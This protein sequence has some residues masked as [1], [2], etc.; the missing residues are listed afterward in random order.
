[1]GQNHWKSQDGVTIPLWGTPERKEYEGA[2]KDKLQS[3]F[4]GTRNTLRKLKVPLAQ[5]NEHSGNDPVNKDRLNLYTRMARGGDRLPPVI[6]RRNG[7]DTFDLIDGS[8]RRAAAH[9]AGLKGLDAYELVPTLPGQPAVKKSLKK[10]AIADI[11]PGQQEHDHYSYSHVLRP[12]HVMAGY[13]LNVHP[14]TFDDG[15][16]E[17]T[18][19]LLHHGNSVGALGGVLHN[20]TLKLDAASIDGPHR[21][22]GLG[23]A[24]YEAMYGHAAHGL[25]ATHAQ[26]DDHSTSAHAVHQKLAQ[27]HGLG[28]SAGPIQNGK[29]PGTDFDGKFGPYQYALKSE[30]IAKMAIAGIP[31]GQKTKRKAHQPGFTRWNY[32]HVLPE[33]HQQAGF[34][35]WLDTSKKGQIRAQLVHDADKPELREGNAEPGEIGM[36]TATHVPGAEYERPLVM[37]SAHVRQSHQGKGLGLAMYEALYAHGRNVLGATHVRGGEHS[38]MAMRVHQKLAQKHGLDYQPRENIG[39]RFGDEK[40]NRAYWEQQPTGPYDDKFKGYKYALKSEDEKD[41]QG[42]DTSF[43]FG[44]NAAPAPVEPSALHV[45]ALRSIKRMKGPKRDLAHAWFQYTQGHTTVRPPVTPELERHLARFGIVDPQGYGYDANG[46]DMSKPLAGKRTRGP[47]QRQPDELKRYKQNS[48]RSG[49][50]LPY[51]KAEEELE[52][53]LAKAFPDWKPPAIAPLTP[54]APK[55]E[56]PGL[57]VPPAA[58]KTPALHST[59]DGFMGQLK[60]LPKGSAERGKFITQHMNHGPFLAAL[61]AHPQGPAM[62]KQ[63]TSYLNGAAN[64]GF[65]AGA[66]RAVVKAEDVRRLPPAE[67]RQLR[68]ALR[69]NRARHLKKAVNLRESSPDTLESRHEV[70]GHM[71][72]FQPHMHRAFKAAR[73]LMGGEPATI[74]Q[75][76]RALWDHDGDASRRHVPVRHARHGGLQEG[77]GGSPECRGAGQGRRGG[78]RAQVR[79]GGRTGRC[80]GRSVPHPGLRRGLVPDGEAE[81]EALHRLHAGLGPRNRPDFPAKTQR[82]R[83]FPGQGGQRGALEPGPPRSRLLA[84]IPPLRSRTVHATG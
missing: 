67:Q 11:P 12:D 13:S 76:R 33:A 44:A 17:L 21:G 69:M 59:V 65:K 25:G 47:V 83:R 28:Y 20:G 50:Y 63:L 49:H 82:W 84:R 54:P 37:G 36:A 51:Q 48:T 22:K 77:P 73:F 41:P 4:G 68:K 74:E 61:Q 10:M 24:M 34:K 30:A 35:L 14:N 42:G 7:N 40:K 32:T 5:I 53:F 2:F 38:T 57:K 1:V 60:T 55:V 78:P 39:E 72:G 19:E 26:G 3:V 31:P 15:S 9:A 18:A 81:R 52:G 45:A 80:T 70:A 62:H 56:V 27:K 6:V 29:V 16:H 64:A 58:M 23:L 79:P 8:H 46:R 43:E 75:M 71:L 66:T